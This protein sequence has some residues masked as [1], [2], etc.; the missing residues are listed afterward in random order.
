MTIVNACKAD[1]IT[2]AGTPGASPYTLTNPVYSGARMSVAGITFSHSEGA[3]CNTYATK[4]VEVSADGG[5]TWHSSGSIY[6]N[7]LS[8]ANN[9]FAFVLEPK[10][11]A[12][13]SGAADY[14]RKVRISV[15]A[16]YSTHANA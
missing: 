4:L 2:L 7:L 14:T 3:P 16:P 10:Q 1:A 15:K 11:A 5:S 9:E 8:S 6:S 12:F 13:D